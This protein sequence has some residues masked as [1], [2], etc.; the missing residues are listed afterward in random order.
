MTPGAA[1]GRERASGREQR[2]S[3]VR[4][5][6]EVAGGGGDT[7]PWFTAA[8]AAALVFVDLGQQHSHQPAAPGSIHHLLLQ[9]HDQQELRA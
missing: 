5:G 9:K 4:R 1:W 7:L 3:G 2:R 6:H 8:A